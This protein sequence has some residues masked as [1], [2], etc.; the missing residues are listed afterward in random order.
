M[1]FPVFSIVPSL[2]GSSAFFSS[3]GA[4]AEG[5][6]SG[7]G[8]G[9]GAGS[10]GAGGGGGG[11]SSFLPHPANVRV[12][13]KSVIPDNEIILPI[14]RFTSFPVTRLKYMFCIGLYRTSFLDFQE[15]LPIKPR[16]AFFT[17]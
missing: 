6:A 3:A 1:D 15:D 5:A 7:A 10:A 14:L 11:G 13:A 12:A 16:Y 17:P 9:A 8:A 4:G 2:A